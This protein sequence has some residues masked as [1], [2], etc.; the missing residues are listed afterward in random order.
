M[1]THEK[2]SLLAR[3]PIRLETFPHTHFQNLTQLSLLAREPIR[4]ETIYN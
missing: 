2:F 3:E 1:S 4:L